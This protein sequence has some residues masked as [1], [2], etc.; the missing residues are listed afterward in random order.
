MAAGSDAEI[1]AASLDEPG[2]FGALFDRRW[3]EFIDDGEHHVDGIATKLQ[4]G[5]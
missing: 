2:R 3:R 1:I 5:I 4:G